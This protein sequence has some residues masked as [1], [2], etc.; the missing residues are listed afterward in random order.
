[1]RFLFCLVLSFPLL[2]NA[3]KLIIKFKE[4]QK[5]T[6][7]MSTKKS[8]EKQ[9]MDGRMVIVD[10]N[11]KDFERQPGIEYVERSQK[12]HVMVTAPR[13]RVEGTAWGIVTTKA[14]NAWSR[15]IKGKGIK[16]AVIDTGVDGTHPELAGRVLPGYNAI[17]DNDASMDDHGHGTHCSGSVAGLNVGMAPEASIVPVKFL[18]KDG[19][20]TLEDAVKAIDWA[21]KQDVQIMSNS[22]GGGGYSKA[23]EDVI[24]AAQAKGIV[25]IAAA[26]NERNNND[27]TKSYPASY[28]DVIAVA[29]S[30]PAD[31]LASFS[32]YGQESVYV[33][34]PGTDIYSS[35]I[36]GKYATWSGTSMATPHVAGA[37]ALML[38]EGC[39]D[40]KACLQKNFVEAAALKTK[41]KLGG[42]LEVQ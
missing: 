30:T 2:A 28:D 42:R 17:T 32:N 40:A 19:S 8:A 6:F 16:I 20:G 22:W 41:T 4:G 14:A 21:T 9:L 38:Q 24:K 25:F 15:N 11:Y 39:A 26:G 18:D 35:V 37:L 3:E 34:A 36:G 23:L 7:V 5:S 29:A 1:M 31:G 27:R 10:G 33:A 13:I 12:Y